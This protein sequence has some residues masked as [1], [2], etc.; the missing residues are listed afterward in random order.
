MATARV[1]V[2]RTAKRGEIIDIRTLISHTM[3]TGFRRD[4]LGKPLLRDII[5]GFVCTYNGVEIC[6]AVLHSAV[7]A[8]PYLAFSTVATESGTLVFRWDGDNGFTF[9]ESAAI[10]V[11]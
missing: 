10:T 2:P 5:T 8:N 11:A 6:R 7:S 1:D 9:T 4:Y 3:E